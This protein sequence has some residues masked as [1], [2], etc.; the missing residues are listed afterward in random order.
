M[1]WQSVEAVPITV[2][3]CVSAARAA[4]VRAALLARTVPLARRLDGRIEPLATASLIAGRRLS[5][6]TAAHIFEHAAVGDLMVPLPGERSWAHLDG[7]RPRVLVHPQRDLALIELAAGVVTQR[8]LAHWRPLAADEIDDEAPCAE[9]VYAVA[10][11]PCSQTRRIDG[12]VYAKP[13]VLFTH[14]LDGERLAYARTAP[15]VDGVEVHTPELDGVSGALVWA[16]HEAAPTAD[17]RLRA[18]A[19]Q[20]AFLHGG[21]MRTEPL[22]AAPILL[23]RLRR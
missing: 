18:A 13:L 5:L 1:A 14:A 11:Y 8:L 6:L 19:M 2:G 7:A 17:C 3:A 9:R 12:T 15:R 23:D 22:G 16:L 20:V 10:G 4:A 21:Y